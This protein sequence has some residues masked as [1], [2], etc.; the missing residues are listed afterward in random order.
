MRKCSMLRNI[1]QWNELRRKGNPKCLR[2]ALGCCSNNTEP[3][4]CCASTPNQPRN[5]TSNVQENTRDEKKKKK[6]ELMQQPENT[7]SNWFIHP[8]LPYFLLSLSL[9]LSLSLFFEDQA[10][11]KSWI[12]LPLW[13]AHTSES[14]FP[15]LIFFFSLPFCKSAS[16]KIYLGV[17]MCWN[18]LKGNL[19]ALS[20][21]KCRCCE[22]N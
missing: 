2:H 7:N 22:V 16:I 13:S 5:E 3:Y 19:S 21:H 4:V 18:R 9:S 10:M 17:Q 8:D 6:G 15:F 12:I 20:K 14:S 1:T 11:V